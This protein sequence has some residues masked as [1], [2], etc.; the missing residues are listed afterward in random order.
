MRQSIARVLF[1]GSC[2]LCRGRAGDLLCGECDADLPRLDFPLLERSGNELRVLADVRAIRGVVRD[3]Q[4]LCKLADD[5][6]FVLLAVRADTF[7]DFVRR[8]P[9][10]RLPGKR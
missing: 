3:R 10:H 4:E 8:R 5:R 1:G 6:R 7:A 2:F 9:G